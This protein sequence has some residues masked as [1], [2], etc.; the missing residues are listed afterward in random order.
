MAMAGLVSG[1]RPRNYESRMHRINS[2]IKAEQYG[3][4]LIESL[5]VCALAAVIL[6]MAIPIL[7][8]TLEQSNA[9]A[10]AQMIAQQLNYARVFAVGNHNNIIV[11]CSSTTNSIIVAPGT[12]SA[13]GPFVLP[14]K[15]K[16]LASAPYPDTPDTLGNTVLGSD[17][18]DQ[19]T[20]LDNGSAATNGA[21]SDLLSGTFF[22]EN[23]AGNP[24]TLRAVTL[25]GG[26]GRVRT[27]RWIPDTAS[28]K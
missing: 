4:S 12:G 24:K 1:N 15:M 6:S 26:T 11:Q 23:A 20:F 7:G 28:W 17:G 10:A 2:V 13:R 5:I 27:W 19:I 25:I 18:K 9:D 16:F 22:I 3:F 8:P 14:G 21:G